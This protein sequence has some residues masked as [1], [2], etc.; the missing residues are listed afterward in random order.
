L[1]GFVKRIVHS[2]VWLSHLNYF[3]GQVMFR[4]G[5]SAHKSGSTHSHMDIDASVQYVKDIFADYIHYGGV[6]E[7]WIRG[8]HILE[9]GP[10]DNLGAGLLFLAKGA[11]SYLAVDRFFAGTDERRNE[12]IY[13]RLYDGLSEKEKE[14]ISDTVTLVGDDGARLQGDR[15]SAIY[16]CAIEKLKERKPDAE[17]DVVLS[18]AVLEHVY[19]LDEAWRNMVALLAPDGR[20]WHKVDF[21]NH[22][23]YSQFH[24]LYFLTISSGLWRIISQPDPTLNRC[25]IGQYKRLGA[26]HFDNTKIYYS[27]ILDHPE[28]VPHWEQ[29]E[30]GE[31][32]EQKDLDCV[33]AIRPQLAREYKDL[34]DEDLLVCGAFVACDG[35]K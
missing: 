2:S 28:S 5:I 16:D 20:M 27:N 23:L 29:L 22:G 10:G 18:R 1:L 13:R 3:K 25:R 26:A 33:N 11:A 21:R 24:P 32:Y 34:T 6:D 17:F 30:L 12:I 8:K 4:L 19:E 15:L 14:A 31:Q 35:K 9:I 7:Q